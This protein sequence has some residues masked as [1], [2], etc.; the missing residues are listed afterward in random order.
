M[1]GAMLIFSYG[2][3]MCTPRLRARVPSAR[4][5]AVARL[6]GH[7]LRFHKRG[8]D[9]SSKA[10]AYRTDAESDHVWGVVFQIDPSEKPELDRAEGLGHGYLEREV[11]VAT[12]TAGTVTALMYYA[13]PAA[14][15]ARLLPFS[16]YTHFVISGAR[17]HALP[18]DYVS[19]LEAVA[20]VQDPD[21]ERDAANAAIARGGAVG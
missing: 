13:A 11:R 2:S 10:D 14:I 17:E 20:A 12:A 6:E 9:G 1:G 19:V 4:R 7:Q 15:D 18:A 8:R 3:N 5:V 16:W 21:P